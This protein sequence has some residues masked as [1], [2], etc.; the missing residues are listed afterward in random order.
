LAAAENGVRVSAWNP[1]G[2]SSWYHYFTHLR[3]ED[4]EKN[5]RIAKERFPFEVFQIDDGY[6]KD[7][8]DWLEAKEGF[9]SLP[10]LAQ[11]IK[12]YGYVAGI[13]TAPFSASE[14][15]RLFQENR[16]WM[17]RDS[18]APKECYKNWGKKIYALD[19]SHPEVNK[20]LYGLFSKL[21]KM[22][23]TYFKVDFLFAAAMPGDRAKKAT[24]IQAYREGMEVIREAVGKSFIL[25]C[26]APLL[27]S[28]GFVEGMRISEDTAPY[29][30]NERGPFQGPNAYHALK[31]S[32]TRSFMHRKW[33]LNDP[34][35]LL[36][37][38]RD[39]ELSP[40]ERELYA[41]AAGALDNM[42]IESDDLELVDEDGRRLLERAIALKGGKARVTGLLGDDF[43]L[44][45]SRGGRAG[46]FSLLA[47]L[48]DL[49]KYYKSVEIPA[50]SVRF[51]EKKEI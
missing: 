36:L 14:T 22:G 9:R 50:H 23:F 42:I 30:D 13:W 5:L 31:N 19:T 46:D 32:I 48:S 2:W 35:C 47:N 24:P 49:S 18:G 1:V 40:N 38:S 20:W 27:P 34:D 3:W 39:I 17:V 8:G 6:E 11:L 10:E 4:I 16:G 37:R 25:G 43:Y 28:A 51:L 21:K 44:I 15:S 33:W 26:G 7:I 45:D 12:S 41:L 29:W